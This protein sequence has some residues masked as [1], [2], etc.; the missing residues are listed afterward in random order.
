M[1]DYEDEQDHL[2]ETPSNILFALD[3]Y[4]WWIISAALI[5]SILST[6]IIFSIEPTYRAEGIILVETQQIPEDLV[7]STV[8]TLADE[9]IKVIEQRVMTRDKLLAI[10]NKHPSLSES[11]NSSLSSVINETRNAISVETITDGR[12]RRASTVAFKVSYESKNPVLAQ[13]ITDDLVTLFLDENVKTRTARAVET[14]DFLTNESMR[15]KTELGETE[16]AIL[17]YK[18]QNRDALPEHLDLYISMR[19]RAETKSN[20]L[21]RQLEEINNQKSLLESQMNSNVR[22]QSSAND[23]SLEK[24]RKEYQRLS[25]MYQPAHPDLVL[26]RKEI[27][28]AESGEYDTMFDDTGYNRVQQTEFSS[29]INALETK[30]KFLRDEMAEVET[31]ISS[32]EEKIIKIPQVEQGLVALNRDYQ[33]V[34]TQ[35]ERLLANTMK[36]QMAENLEQDLKAERFSLVEPPILPDRPFKPDIKKMI[37]ASLAVSIGFPIGIVLL[38]GFL[39]KSIRGEKALEIIT[40]HAP[41][42]VVGYIETEDEMKSKAL[43]Q[44]TSLVAAPAALI[45]ITL[46]IH[47]LYLPIDTLV[48]E[49][50]FRLR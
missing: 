47:F 14:T 38:I 9:R 7:Q 1:Y 4:K 8:T 32:L 50:I 49:V 34:K 35:Y 20:D 46:S 40:G 48:H 21:R 5:L 23:L 29:K 24:L 3:R 39:D 37:A 19:E 6:L 16:H 17:L 43:S 12:K 44:R 36:A 10:I 18:Q 30:R 11:A 42:A 28:Q 45:L 2:R 15:L 33:A 31:K 27:A 26:L 25:L 22:S 41:I 13:A